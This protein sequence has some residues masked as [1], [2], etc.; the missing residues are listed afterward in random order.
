MAN[1]HRKRCPTAVVTG[2]IQ[3]KTTRYHYTPTRT[4]KIKNSDYTN[5]GKDA[6]TESLTH[7]GGNAKSFSYSGKLFSSFLEIKYA[8]TL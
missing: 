4:A 2:K 7:T 3:I 6:E 1:K 8:T 5:A